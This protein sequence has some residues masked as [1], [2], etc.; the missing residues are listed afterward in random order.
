[1]QDGGEGTCP[2]SQVLSLRTEPVSGASFSR[3]SLYS[4]ESLDLEVF[5]YYIHFLLR[6]SFM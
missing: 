5:T 3:P 1:M 2:K 4:W 6:F